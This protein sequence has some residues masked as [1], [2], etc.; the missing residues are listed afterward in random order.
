MNNRGELVYWGAGIIG[1]TCLEQHPDIKPQYF[2]DSNW[3]KASI[4]NIPVKKPDEIEDWNK[5]FIVITTTA[6]DEIEALLNSKKLKKNENYIG[7]KDF[8]SVNRESLNENLVTVTSFL[9]KNKIYKRATLIIAPVFVSRESNNMIRF[10]R[11]YG[12]KRYPQK[13][14]LFSDLGVLNEVEAQHMIGYPVFKLPEICIWRGILRGCD[15][16][17]KGSLVHADFLSENE[18]EWVMELEK[19]K[20]YA[21]KELSYKITMEIYWYF[22]EILSILNPSKIIIWGGWDRESYILADLA[23]QLKIPYGFMEHGWI[24]GTIQFDRRGISGQSEYA[25]EPDRILGRSIRNKDM[26]IRAIKNYIAVNKMDTGKFRKIEEDETN[27]QCIDKRK[28]TVFFVGM[29]EHGMGINPQSDYWKKYVSSIFL[30]T[31]E[32]VLFVAEICKRNDW[33]FVFKPHPNPAN[34]DELD[35][36]SLNGNIIQVK[37]TEIDRLI[38]LADVVVSI[39]SAVDYKVLMYEKPLVQVGHTTLYKK[40]CSYEV[41]SK[42]MIE[43]RIRAAMDNGMTKEQN[44]NFEL[45]MARLLENYLWDDLSERELRYGLS[46]DIDFFDIERNAESQA[47]A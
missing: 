11:Q 9:E 33:N 2:I 18:K 43:D 25:V 23:Q 34:Q 44:E 32:A 3:E 10:F 1:R 38:Q 15:N 5:I 17:D 26:D 24:P 31:K 36:E 14:I 12:I 27:L 20:T 41:S 42:E 37:Y 35:K 45:H 47:L 30:S 13:S 40:G 29:G 21:N 46:L 7:Y 28:K 19:R 6:I 16:I 39:A 8:F 4:N 22:K